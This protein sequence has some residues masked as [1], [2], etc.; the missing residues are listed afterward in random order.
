M[1]LFGN[2]FGMRWPVQYADVPPTEVWSMVGIQARVRLR[3]RRIPPGGGC[4]R[5]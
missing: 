3:H 2:L 5:L 1:V 4:Q